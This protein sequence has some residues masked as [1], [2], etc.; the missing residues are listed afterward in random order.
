MEGGV[1]RKEPETG[2]GGIRIDDKAEKE[3][4]GKNGIKRAQI[5]WRSACCGIGD[6]MD[7]NTSL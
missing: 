5:I 4:V 6:N 2:L 1:G 3:W 7:S